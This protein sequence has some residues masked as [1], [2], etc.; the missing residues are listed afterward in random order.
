MNIIGLIVLLIVIGTTIWLTFDAKTNKIPFTD[1]PYSLNNGALA[2]FLTAVVIWIYAFPIYL[3]R[4]A[5]I[6]RERRSASQQPAQ[7]STKSATTDMPDFDQQLRRLAKLK[8]DGIISSE[9]FDKKKKI[10]LGL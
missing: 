8:E 1:K 7:P 5:K 10:L 6:M 9:E 2:W 3:Q 4:R